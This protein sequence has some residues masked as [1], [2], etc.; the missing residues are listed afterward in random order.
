[1]K[2]S[3]KFASDAENGEITRAFFLFCCRPIIAPFLR[4]G[5]K[6]ACK[7]ELNSFY[8]KYLYLSDSLKHNTTSVSNENTRLASF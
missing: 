6:N 8:E 7:K 1:V 3:L 2:K 4:E 5:E